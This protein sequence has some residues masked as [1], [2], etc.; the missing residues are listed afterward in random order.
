M[1]IGAT[2]ATA[3]MALGLATGTAQ[4]QTQVWIPPDQGLA[5]IGLDSVQIDIDVEGFVAR[6]RM[7]L[8]FANPNTRVLEGEFVFPLGP[9]Q[10]VSG[11]EL[12]V[13]GRLRAGVVVPRQTARVAFEDTIRQQIDPGL[14]ELT[15]GNVFR[16]RLYPIPANGSKRIAL[17]FE[18]VLADD[19]DHQRYVLPLRFDAPVRRFAVN[20]QA[21]GHGSVASEPA[22]P[23]RLLSFDRA[24]EAWVASFERHDVTP[25]SELSFRIP[26]QS[27]GVDWMLAADALDPAWMTWVARVDTGL[28]A[29]AATAPAPRQISVYYD[30]SA[31][32]RERD[33][34]RELAAL[35]TYLR[36][37]EQVRVELIAFRDAA[38]PARRFNVEGGNADALLAAIR[39]LPL[40]GGSSYGAI[41]FGVAAR[42][43]LALVIGDG[44]SNFG[45]ADA[46][47]ARAGSGLVV[48]VLH[49]AQKLDAARLDAIAGL[50]GG[51][52]IDLLHNDAEAAARA[53]ARR[54]WRLLAVESG[55]ATCVDLSP[56]VGSTVERTM[57][58]G[59][60]CRD[61][62]VDAGLVLVFGR[63]GDTPAHRVTLRGPA[64]RARG[65]MAGS[66]HRLWAQAHLARL[67]AQA[68]PDVEAITALATR[69]GV[70]TRHTSLLV[71]DRIEDYVRY[72]I[73]PPEPELRERYH[74][75]LAAQPKPVP[76][77]GRVARIQALAEQ[78]QAFREWHG[79]RHQ[80]LES[81]LL[82]IAQ[83]EHANWRNVPDSVDGV[84][85]LRERSERLL[86]LSR[87]LAERWR[88]DGAGDATRQRWESEAAAVMHD[89]D[90]LRR[91]RLELAPGS[92]NAGALSAAGE[93]G[94]LDRIEVAGHRVSAAAPAD[95]G[96]MPMPA[97][98]P[99]PPPPPPP[100]EAAPAAEMTADTGSTTRMQSRA[101]EQGTPPA[102]SAGIA[103]AGWNPDTPYLRVLRDADDP[104]AA[105]LGERD[106]HGNAP[107]F[108]LDCAD[109]FR[110][111]AR[112]PAIAVRVLSNIAELGLDDTALT[113]VLAYRLAQWDLYAL[114]VGQFEAALA[115]RPEE[116]QSYRDLALALSRLPAPRWQRAV[117]LLWQVAVGEWHGRFPG[118]EL[119][120]LHELNDLLARAGAAAG[121]DVAAL[122]IP[123]GLLQPL[124]VGLRVVLTWD[125]DNTDIDLWVI[126]PA[127]DK[128]YYG[129]S[130]TRSGGHVSRD[131]TQGYGPEVFT[132]A[133]PLPGTYRVQ[134]NYFGDRRQSVSG[135]VTVQVEFQTGFGA[136]GGERQAITRRLESGRQTI[137]LGEFRIGR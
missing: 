110:D 78:W 54:P 87:Q 124:P 45:G 81:L 5:P 117:E 36:G 38:E 101:L 51:V 50:G 136:A 31:S 33:R 82:P 75:L 47:P 32:A 98:A 55:S 134:V 85:G 121:I 105:Y 23:D 130:Q 34:E 137:D 88:D 129:Q 57:L 83:Q 37:L 48:H 133:R 106:A 72:R 39:A 59:G 19:G 76:D 71:L 46:R 108:F 115:Q 9:G 29:D 67:D 96:A 8:V 14:A 127:G 112:Q 52:R 107:S 100:S 7:E 58:L 1:N 40:D 61:L 102:L 11:Y 30:A 80:W 3:A 114:A 68:T 70:V 10:T 74:A 4:A 53:M 132:I 123:A 131:F 60:R 24:G 92:G 90:Q 84:A 77:A 99:P 28:P 2:V 118:I 79:R 86:E 56:A 125:A 49:A 69:Y 89:L 135:P 42:S 16:T 12:E 15:Q 93:S 116:P 109:F 13:E 6:T 126:D 62:D 25:Q 18:Q 26:R 73:E 44:L 64:H 103:I 97:T 91:L 27:G 41:D 20:V 120:A 35:Q 21:R 128:A 119:I 122:Q 113:R 65:D 22:S 94:Q 63:D 104:Y 95:A 111:E 66:V 43:Q 17:S